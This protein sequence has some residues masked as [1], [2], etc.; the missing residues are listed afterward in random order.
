MPSS[1]TLVRTSRAACNSAGFALVS[2]L[3]DSV[4]CVPRPGPRERRSSTAPLENDPTLAQVGAYLNSA[5][6][7]REVVLENVCKRRPWLASVTGMAWLPV[8]KLPIDDA[9]CRRRPNCPTDPGTIS[10]D[11]LPARSLCGSCCPN[12]ESPSSSGSA[13]R[14]CTTCSKTSRGPVPGF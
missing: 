9:S 2:T 10:G 12:S 6:I 3:F 14:G 1:G 11:D 4:T 8:P 7:G 13:S 5:G